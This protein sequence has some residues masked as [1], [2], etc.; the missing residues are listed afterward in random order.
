MGSDVNGEQPGAGAGVSIRAPAWG[1]TALVE[2]IAHPRKVSI[3]APAWGATYAGLR[4]I[5]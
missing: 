4:W 1:A 5:L 2:E 3:R